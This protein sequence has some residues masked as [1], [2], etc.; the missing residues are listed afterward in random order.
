VIARADVVIGQQLPAKVIVLAF[1]LRLGLEWPFPPP[2]ETGVV[3]QGED[4]VAIASLSRSYQ[5]AMAA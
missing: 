5:R 1:F 3:M 4:E 2:P